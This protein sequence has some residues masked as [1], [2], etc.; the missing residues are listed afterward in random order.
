VKCALVFSDRLDSPA[1]VD[2]AYREFVAAHGEASVLAAARGLAAAKP[3]FFYGGEKG[4]LENEMRQAT[5]PDA[6]PAVTA[7]VDSPQYLAWRDFASGATATYLDLKPG[8]T[9]PT[10][11][12]VLDRQ[13][14]RLRSLSDANAQVWV[15]RSHRAARAAP[16]ERWASPPLW[17]LRSA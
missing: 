3:Y 13:T 6:A 7:T 15:T 1:A 4:R 12:N 16:L 17:N 11:N 8:A 5:A 2:S 9:E 10:P 14:Y